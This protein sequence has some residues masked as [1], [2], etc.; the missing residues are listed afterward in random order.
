[1]KFLNKSSNKNPNVIIKARKVNNILV[2]PKIKI[3]NIIKANRN[4]IIEII[5]KFT[6]REKIIFSQ[7]IKLKIVKLYNIDN[8][9]YI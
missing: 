9:F 4:N 1:M 8:F 2:P 3:I 6:F 5:F 7:K